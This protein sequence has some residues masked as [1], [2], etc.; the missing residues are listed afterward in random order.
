MC[1]IAAV[2]LPW[3]IEIDQRIVTHGL[4][5]LAEQDRGPALH[6]EQVVVVAADAAAGAE[7]LDL[8]GEAVGQR[9]SPPSRARKAPR[10]LFAQ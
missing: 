9:S 10:A 4:D 3:S 7:Q 6:T 8:P 1:P 5:V 2:T